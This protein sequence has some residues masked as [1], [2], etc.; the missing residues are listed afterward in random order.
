MLASMRPRLGVV[1]IL[2]MALLGFAA[3]RIPPQGPVDGPA[4]VCQTCLVSVRILEDF[5]CDPAA[6][7]FL[8][9]FVEKQICP[10]MGDTQQCHNLAEGLLPTL[11][12]WF[13]ASATPASL[14]SSAGVCGGVVALSNIPELNRPSL[15]VR[16]TAECA[17]CEFVVGQAK[18]ALNSSQALERLKQVALQAC[19]GLPQQLAD[20]CTQFVEMYEPLMAE[21]IEDM[22]PET[23]CGLLGV[24]VEE[25]AAVP[26]PPLPAALVRELAGTKALCRPPPVHMAMLL[27]PLTMAQLPRPGGLLGGLMHGLMHRLG[28]GRGGPD[29]GRDPRDGLDP[30]D[31][32]GLMQQQAVQ[33]L[34]KQ[35]D[36]PRDE[37]DDD[38]EEERHGGPM[39][40][41]DKGWMPHLHHDDDDEERE[42]EGEHRSGGMM[43]GRVLQQGGPMMFGGAGPMMGGGAANDACDY[44]KMAV[45]EAHS[46]VS[47]PAVQAEMLNYTLAVCGQFPSF[48]EPCKLYVTMYAPLVFQ[49][50]EQY[51]VPD[52]VCA[53]TGMCPPPPAAAGEQEAEQQQQAAAFTRLTRASSIHPPHEGPMG[54]LADSWLGRLLGLE[55]REEQ[56]LGG[57]EEEV[58]V[59]A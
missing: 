55:G 36:G 59:V 9:D 25:W 37:D 56:R 31:M 21:L 8:V 11:I 44:C 53:Q 39:H 40:G 22:D 1:A 30:E 6:T 52:A 29:M 3:A 43:G 10:S 26:P 46:L 13:R 57:E 54:W 50:L 33:A 14:C 27:P 19:A 32:P 49:L 2:A 48:A 15:R 24:C 4:D 38:D 20:S 28:F 17:M 5:L 18:V 35:R 7:D 42:E 23:V 34:Q 41:G 45:I 16:D 51:L 12:Q 58:R 47:N